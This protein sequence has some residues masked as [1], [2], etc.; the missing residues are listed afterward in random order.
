MA[1]LSS[2]RSSS[3]DLASS[4]WLI[5]VFD[6]V[7][8]SLPVMGVSIA[9]AHFLSI[10]MLALGFSW[11]VG[12]D[13]LYWGEFQRGGAGPIVRWDLYTDI[14]KASMVGYMMAAGYYGL[15]EAGRD[16]ECLRP[17]LSC[18]EAEFDGMLNYLRRVTR[19]PL[20]FGTALALVWSFF[21]PLMGSHSG[22]PTLGS[23]R[24]S[25]HQ[26]KEFLLVF[27]IFRTVILELN[28]AFFFAAVARRFARIELLDL[29]Q[30]APFLRRALRGVLVLVLFSAILSLL[31]ILDT[32]PS[33]SIT[34]LAWIVLSAVAVFLIPLVPLRRR[35]D[36][37][38][39]AELARVRA[40]LRLEYEAK[41]A[42]DEGWAPRADLIVYE[43]RVEQVS[44][45]ALNTPT[46]VRFALY[47]S[48]G[49]GSWLGAALVERGLGSLLGP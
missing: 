44:T 25:F 15:R 20:Y 30:V 19:R 40:A 3:G 13:F 26:I 42:G 27:F 14:V 43:Q 31:V 32:N 1:E 6:R 36:A 11:A 46:V 17:A 18:D 33:N 21:V 29:E 35:I 12:G 22:A 5:R 45:W 16:L 34:G 23:A 7:P 10:T 9:L 39:R 8:L 4:P 47:V 49:I 37:A 48:L 2:A 28:S 41:I 38:K 24:M